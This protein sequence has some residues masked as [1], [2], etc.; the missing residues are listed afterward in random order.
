MQSA[1]VGL[2]L[3]SA[4]VEPSP[5]I[6]PIEPVLVKEPH[7]SDTPLRETQQESMMS[8]EPAAIRAF[9]SMV[10]FGS[11]YKCQHI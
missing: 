6:V 7:I 10:C 4:Q 1:S 3:Q 11:K 9:R 8:A 2:H 5:P